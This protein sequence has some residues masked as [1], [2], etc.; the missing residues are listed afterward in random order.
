MTRGQALVTIVIIVGFLAALAGFVV[1]L[2]LV[3]IDIRYRL[4]RRRRGWG[5]S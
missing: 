3:I 1:A 5:R 4:E 2:N